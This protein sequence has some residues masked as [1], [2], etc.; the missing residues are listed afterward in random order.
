MG[1]IPDIPAS[2]RHQ[3]RGLQEAHPRESK[4]WEWPPFPP[5]WQRMSTGI[6]E[7]NT[8]GAEFHGKSNRTALPEGHRDSGKG[9]GAPGH[10]LGNAAPGPVCTREFFPTL[11]VPSRK[12]WI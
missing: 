6:Q 7:Q 11:L 3:L 1:S 2:H 8:P 12:S 9:L 10:S 5:L 4:A